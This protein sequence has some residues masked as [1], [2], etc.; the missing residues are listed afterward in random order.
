VSAPREVSVPLGRTARILHPQAV[1]FG[2]NSADSSADE[3]M[4]AERRAVRLR[5]L[6]AQL[7]RLER[8]ARLGSDAAA[9]DA[10]VRAFRLAWRLEH[11][12]PEAGVSAR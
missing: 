7:I 9:R 5:V 10:A 1:G 3:A 12:E 4:S 8:R 2:P 11:E 6:A